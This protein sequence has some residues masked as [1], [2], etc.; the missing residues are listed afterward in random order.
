KALLQ[1]CQ[2]NFNN[3]LKQWIPI[4]SPLDRINPNIYTDLNAPPTFDEWQQALTKYS[5]S[6]AVG[7]SGISYRHL[8]KLHPEVY[9]QL[10]VW[11]GQIFATGII[12]MNWKTSQLF[13]IPKPTNWH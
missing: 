13:P 11:A 3:I 6:S 10:C 2:H 7:M 4:Y 5:P 8:K 12:P 1:P 9:E